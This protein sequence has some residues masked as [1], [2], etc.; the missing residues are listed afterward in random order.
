MDI[1]EIINKLETETNLNIK[2][3][4]LNVDYK[5]IL[6]ELKEN[7]ININYLIETD[8]QI[9]IKELKL[10]SI[11]KNIINE[12]NNLFKNKIYAIHIYNNEIVIKFNFEIENKYNFGSKTK[13]F[14]YM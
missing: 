6:I 2:D 7:L 1:I 8:K 13:E 9:K 5:E 12:L 11:Q 10:K 3:I 14:Y 4:S